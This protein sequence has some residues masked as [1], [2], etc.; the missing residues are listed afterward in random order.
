MS[1]QVAVNEVRPHVTRV[2]AY[3][4]PDGVGQSPAQLVARGDAELAEDVAQVVL[5]RPGAQEQAR[6]D[7]RIGEAVARHAGDLRLA[8]SCPAAAMAPLPGFSPVAASS[9]R[10]RSANA[11]APIAANIPGVSMCGARTP[12]ARPSRGPRL[13][14]RGLAWALEAIVCQHLSIARVAQG[15]GVA[16]NTANDADTSAVQRIAQA[17]RFNPPKQIGT[18]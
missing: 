15:L 13:S 6:P 5:D 11:S 7:L 1:I 3:G 8:A 12:A 17:A 9:R 16:W 2:A 14:R 18:P 4:D 10:A